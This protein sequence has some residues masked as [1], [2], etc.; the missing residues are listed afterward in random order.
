MTTTGLAQRIDHVLRPLGFKRRE[1][2]WNRSR[3]RF[4]DVVE[5]LISRT[6]ER[7]T[8]DLGIFDAA[9]FTKTFGEAPPDFPEAP[10][11]AARA[12]LGALVSG[13]RDKWWQLNEPGPAKEIADS[14]AATALPWFAAIDSTDALIRALSESR[15]VRNLSAPETIY[16]A[17]LLIE[18]QATNRACELLRAFSARSRGAWVGKAAALIR[19]IGC[20]T[21]QT[22]TDRGLARP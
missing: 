19:D 20:A 11:C 21:A 1:A 9:A 12:R 13:G 7:V 6:G 4:I 16:L 17:N 5:L 22:D 8:V 18:R 10:D 2:T 15:E 3:D 14:I